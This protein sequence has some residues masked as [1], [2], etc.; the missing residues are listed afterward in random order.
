[1]TQKSKVRLLLL[2][3]VAF[4]SLGLPDAVLGVA[5]PSIREAFAL[6][7]SGMGLVLA[8]IGT[9]Y[10]IASFFT[11]RLLESMTIGALLAVSSGLVTL[12]LLGYAIAPVW[13]VFLF[14]SLFAGLGAGAIDAGLNAY[15]AAH[16]SVRHM[17]WLHASYS[18]GAMLGPIIMTLVLASRWSWRWGYAVVGA[19]MALMFLSFTLTRSS[20]QGA[21]LRKEGEAASPLSTPQ[22]LRHPLVWLQMAAFFVYTGIEVTAGQWSFTLYTEGR[23]VEATEAGVFAGMY[24]ASIAAGRI[25]L[26]FLIE[27][28]G[29]DRL[30][31]FCTVGAVLGS[32]AF[33]FAPVSL[34]VAGLA[35]VGLSLAPVF[36]TLMS[37]TPSRLPGAYAAHAVGFQVSAGMLGIIFLP[38]LAGVLAA[39]YGLASVGAV[40]LAAA[41]ALLALHEVLLRATAPGR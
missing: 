40:T 22:A 34:S 12:S 16:F 18:I 2:A 5:W 21:G 6:P 9:G 14:S 7:Q 32:A 31:R 17:N 13:A 28:L 8:G 11:G 36:P 24:W 39:R 41:L 33:A 25:F 35:L 10:I 26:G 37:R 29:P 38:S 23:G 19:V 27:W 15:G 30:L 20:W 1:M 3:Y 4:V